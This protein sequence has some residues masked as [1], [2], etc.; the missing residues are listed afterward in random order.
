MRSGLNNLLSVPLNVPAVSEKLRNWHKSVLRRCVMR[1]LWEEQQGE[2]FPFSS[3]REN[4]WL[5]GILLFVTTTYAEMWAVR[6]AYRLLRGLGFEPYG[7]RA[8]SAAAWYHRRF[9]RHVVRGS[10]FSML[11]RWGQTRIPFWTEV[12]IMFMAAEMTDILFKITV[13]ILGAAVDG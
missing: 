8:G 13:V 1:R 10:M 4:S 11:K 9:H 3:G 12:S 7:I 2:T 6:Q 5:V